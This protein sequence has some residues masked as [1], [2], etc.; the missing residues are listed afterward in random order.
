VDGGISGFWSTTALEAAMRITLLPVVIVC[1]FGAASQRSAAAPIHH[2]DAP[3]R[4][5]QFVDKNEGWAVGDHGIIWHSIDGGKSWERQASGTSASLR[6]VHFLTPY[7]GWAV[8]RAEVPHG[9]G[10]VGVVLRTTDGGGTWTELSRGV[11]PGLNGLRFFDEN[12]GVVWGDGS[13]SLPAGVYQ[14]SDSG[15]TWM[16]VSGGRAATWLTGDFTDAK[17]GVVGGMWTGLAPS[18]GGKLT[19]AELPELGG[20]NIRG[21]SM[22]GN[23]GIAVGDGGLVLNTSDG[24]LKW[25]ASAL[26][27]SADAAYCWDLHCVAARGQA[28]LLAGS[29]GSAMARS[30]DAGQTWK[31]VKTGWQ[32]PIHSIFLINE[33]LGWAVGDFGVI[34]GTSDG[35]Q[36]WTQQKQG[37]RKASVLFVNAHAASVP[38]DVMAVAAKDGYHCAAL[39]VC[40]PDI[41]TTDKNRARDGFRLSSAVR[42][43]G[44]MASETNWAFPVPAYFD[45]AKS[46]S[47]LLA[48]NKSHGNKAHEHLVRRLTLAC[49]MWQPEVI[50]AERIG[51]GVGPTE[52]LVL[53]A[54][55]QAFKD[56]EDAKLYPELSELGL[57]ASSPKKLY[58]I[59]QDVGKEG[60][61]VPCVKIDL[62]KFDRTLLDSPRGFAEP[63]FG[64]LGNAHAPPTLRRLNL[65]SHRLAGSEK[66]DTLMAGTVLAAGG[67]SRRAAAKLDE[68]V[69]L[70]I[71]DRDKAVAT[72]RQLESLSEAT[73]KG[74]AT[75]EAFVAAINSAISGGKKSDSEAVPQLPDD[76]AERMVLSL[77]RQQSVEGNTV[78]ARELFAMVATRYEGSAG[79][80]EALRWLT[81]YN[82]SGEARR[83]AERDG[84]LLQALKLEL[85]MKY[86]GIQQASL[87]EP[88][89]ENEAMAWSRK[90][91]ELEAKIGMFGPLHSR[92]PRIVMAA[93]ASRRNLGL[94]ADAGKVVDGYF[95]TV[96]AALQMTPGEDLWRDCLA[97]EAWLRDPSA[98]KAQPKPLALCPR[99]IK[100]PM[101]DG[102][103]DDEC[104]KAFMPL[105][106]QSSAG[107]T[108]GY[109]T[110]VYMT[111]DD[112]FLYVAATCTHPEG[113]QLPKAEKRRRDDDLSGR[114]RIELLFDLDRDYQSF[115]RLR[116][117]QRGCVA[118]DCTGDRTWNPKWFVAV[119]P[120]P[121]GWTAEI[122]IPLSEFVNKTPTSG[123]TWAMNATR[124]LPGVGVQSWSGPASATVRPEGMGLMRFHTK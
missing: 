79:S 21:I 46:D 84:L 9:E 81:R 29:P 49:R 77:A 13:D 114:D 16:A 36:T 45:D 74:F 55:Q 24:G 106:L 103:L 69:E 120:T 124:V 108:G 86:D 41:A 62:T 85:P 20:R 56:A 117:D 101:L 98:V 37:G 115:F 66:H 51:G 119:D 25:T 42:Q 102:R 116:V 109:K 8:G 38:V 57:A 6:S 72:R 5:V 47:L 23:N 91:L 118:D 4:A 61:V 17:T 111:Y 7:T 71:A 44:G 90:C 73:S 15:K 22:V 28:M 60:E 12:T 76:F 52:Q 107:N 75:K 59:G 80:L 97:A 11:L 122:A 26:P 33:T 34:L 43:V 30:T 70:I 83:R 35:G 18:K 92:D 54:M 100:K 27:I 82:G 58:A 121:T 105:D 95:R 88:V 39:A 65:V 87:I 31:V 96:P 63:A 112:E 99:T 48:W 123:T 64:L 50:V 113:K 78:A 110:Q 104:W 93:L 1:L 10:S 40:G 68:S 94:T 67:P 89:P 53:S 19:P 14:T 3:L 2:D 32:T